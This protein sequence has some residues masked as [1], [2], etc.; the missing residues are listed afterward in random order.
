MKVVLQQD[1]EKLGRA[2][3][4]IEV[5][6]G[7]ARNY[8]IPR[9]LADQ[10]TE[11]NVRMVEHLKRQAGERQRKEQEASRL[12]AE[13]IDAARVTIPVQMGEAG[14]MFGSVTAK[15]IV[16]ALQREGIA[17]DRRRLELERPIKELGEF[18][19]KV[20]L[21]P[22]VSATLRVYVVPVEQT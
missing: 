9:Q 8:L 19:I 18:P 14:K 20:R 10:A 13:K 2:G 22:E 4:L 7:Y 1:V 15:D 21:H 6:D 11:R 16:D 5:A 12:L 17:L 3:D